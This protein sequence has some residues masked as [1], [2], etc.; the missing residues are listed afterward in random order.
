MQVYTVILLVLSV[1]LV[2]LSVVL[3]KIYRLFGNLSKGIE[4]DLTKKGFGQVYK[5]LDLLETDSQ[6]HIQKIGLVRFNPFK[7]MGG[8]QSFALTILDGQNSGI[9]ITGLHT[10]DRTRVYM[11]KILQG[12][13]DHDLS[14]E[15]K[16]SLDIACK[17]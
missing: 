8:D 13:P 14:L 5:R 6:K 4:S 1:W 11:K 17:R 7:E 2:A 3:F 10:R 15:E 12:K 16:K 9:I